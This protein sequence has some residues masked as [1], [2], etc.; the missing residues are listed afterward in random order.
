MAMITCPRDGFHLQIDD[1]KPGEDGDFLLVFKCAY[2]NW[3]V[4]HSAKV[5][6]SHHNG[7]VRAWIRSKIQEFE[8]KEEMKNATNGIRRS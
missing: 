2:C 4:T 6:N 7:R 3:P 1:V 8:R 5:L